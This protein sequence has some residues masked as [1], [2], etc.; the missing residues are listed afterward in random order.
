MLMRKAGAACVLAISL[1]GCT[2]F[3]TLKPVDYRMPKDHAM[4][5]PVT[6]YI[7]R[8]VL[9][10]RLEVPRLNAIDKYLKETNAFFALGPN[11]N[12]EYC[13]D[14]TL[15]GEFR[16]TIVDMA[17]GIAGAATLG[18]LPM[19][20]HYTNILTVTVLKNGSKIKTY[21]YRGDYD[22]VV[23]AFNTPERMAGGDEFISLHNLVNEFVNDLDNDN[24]LPRVGQPPSANKEHSA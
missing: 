9:V 12:S 8:N 10:S 13:I 4:F 7:D 15:S 5:A 21:Q 6:V 19:R 20:D 24:L 22:N 16:N 2:T 11:I 17:K 3:G 18:V 1:G 14:I 23:S